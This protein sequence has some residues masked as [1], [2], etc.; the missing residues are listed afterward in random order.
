MFATLSQLLSHLDLPDNGM[1][2]K[3]RLLNWITIAITLITVIYTVLFSF[4]I[5]RLDIVIVGFFAAVFAL[6]I[7]LAVRNGHSRMAT[8]T[9]VVGVWLIVTYQELRPGGLG[10]F[11]NA[12]TA[13]VVPILLAGVLLGSRESFVFAFVSGLVGLSFLVQGGAKPGAFVDVQFNSQVLRFTGQSLLFLLAATLITLSH[14]ATRAALK[15]AHDSED[16]LRNHNRE[17]EREIAERQQVELALRASDQAATQFQH[18]LKALHEVSM[19]LANVATLDDLYRQAVVLGHDK[20]GFDRIG[21]FV[22]VEGTEVLQGTYGIDPEGNLDDVHDLKTT[23]SLENWKNNYQRFKSNGH[24]YFRIDTVLNDRDRIVGKGWNIFAAVSDGDEIIGW[25]VADNHL[26]HQPLQDF[27]LEIMRL[28]GAMLGQLFAQKQA[29]QMLLEK[30][31]RLS[32]ALNA[33]NMRSWDWNLQSGEI[34]GS[35]LYR[36]NVPTKTNYL[37]FMNLIHVDDRN[38]VLDAIRAMTEAKGTYEAE[39]RVLDDEGTA[40]WLYSLGQPYRD[41][42]GE[43]VG[44]AGVTQDITGRKSIEESLKRADQQ[45]MELILEKERV[46]ALTEFISTISHD[47]RV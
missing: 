8:I 36:E 4:I 13:Y 21:W 19:E 30:D 38:R 29:Q 37:D 15:R 6:G 7:N 18:L 12:F 22:C 23:V 44:V 10:V 45:A 20:L 28:Y 11:D 25:I 47:L 9:F 26:H 41:S 40:R 42:N 43:I 1:N 31:L 35:D 16:S 27:Q 17:L 2:R 3:E 33:A 24:V 34:S 32:L 46:G 5:A 14:N 39:Y